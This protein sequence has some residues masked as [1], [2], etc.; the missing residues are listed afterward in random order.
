MHILFLF[1]LVSA[2]NLKQCTRCFQ[3]NAYFFMKYIIY[4]KI[5][6]NLKAQ[7]NV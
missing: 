1:G 3:F 4:L 5:L 2:Q 6:S 7:V